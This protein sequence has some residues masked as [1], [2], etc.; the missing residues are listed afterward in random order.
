M[1]V[2]LQKGDNLE[3]MR[4]YAK[5]NLRF[6]LVY[7]DPPFNTGWTFKTTDGQFAFDDRW[8]NQEHYLFELGRRI[9][10]AWEILDLHGTLV[11][12]VDPRTSHYVKVECDRLLGQQFF[13]NEI[14]WRYRRWPTVTPAFQ[15]VHDVLLVYRRSR[16][17]ERWTQL[18]E[19]LAPS[20]VKTW[21]TKKQAAVFREGKRV[22]SSVL[23]EE[24]KGVPMGDVWEIP[25]IAPVS[26]E[27]TGYICKCREQREPDESRPRDTFKSESRDVGSSCTSSNGS[28]TTA[29]SP[30]GIRSTTRTRTSRTTGS[31]TS[32]C[33]ILSPTSESIRGA[34]SATASG[35]SR[36]V[37]AKS[38]NPSIASIGTSSEAAAGLTI[39]AARPATS[40]T[41][42]NGSGESELHCET[43][44]KLRSGSYPTQ[45]P[46][47]LLERI[48][49]AYTKPDD[50]VLDPY[51]GSG[52]TL[53]A[54]KRLGRD[55]MGIDSGDLAYEI[56]GKRIKE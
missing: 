11:V 6:D 27:R 21:G 9:S 29:Q 46:I 22:R 44:G 23:E 45:K 41:S 4:S 54:A 33:S 40:R 38:S 14:I 18:Y 32:N 34:S 12:H 56:A 47:K 52:T 20:T 42:S 25:I 7:M 39:R 1:T 24:S 17:V 19:P 51:C 55:A 5:A 48:I 2:G 31:R 37:S 28:G 49:E 26:K 3:I 50:V 35:G 13:A 43:C 16:A 53:V 10:L 8:Q 30:T 15:S 36:V